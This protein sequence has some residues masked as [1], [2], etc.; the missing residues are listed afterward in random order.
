M[1]KINFSARIWL[2]GER[3]TTGKILN[4]KLFFLTTAGS[5]EENK[6]R[7]TIHLICKFLCNIV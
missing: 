6:F 7:Q 3:K 2:G 1:S 4:E 5:S